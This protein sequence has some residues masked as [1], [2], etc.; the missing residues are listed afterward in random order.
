MNENALES[1][2]TRRQVLAAAGQ[3]RRAGGDRKTHRGR[4]IGVSTGR[5]RGF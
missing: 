2:L 4:V 1:A 3:A 5:G